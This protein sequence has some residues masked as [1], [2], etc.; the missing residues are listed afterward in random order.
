MS[1]PVLFATRG[2]RSFSEAVD[3]E[4]Q[5][6]LQKWGDQH[7]PLGTG[8]DLSKEIAEFSKLLCQRLAAEGNVT[9]RHILTEEFR[10]AMAASTTNELYEEL[11]QVVAVC[12]MIINDLPRHPQLG[13]E[14][15]VAEALDEM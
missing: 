13:G 7:H 10:E 1:Y 11:I 5:R 4:C 8:S 15:Y 3:T 12:F 6:I 2:M 9:W 14:P